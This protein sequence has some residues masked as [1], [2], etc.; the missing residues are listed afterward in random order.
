[1]VKIT[2]DGHQ[3]SSKREALLEMQR[4]VQTIHRITPNQ[5]LE[6]RDRS[7]FVAL[8]HNRSDKDSYG[9]STT[10]QF[11]VIDHP[12]S[13]GEIETQYRNLPTISEWTPFSVRKCI[14]GKSG[15]TRAHIIHAMRLLID[16]QCKAWR[17][18]FREDTQAEEKESLFDLVAFGGSP[19]YACA[20]CASTHDLQVDH[21]PVLFS[22]LAEEFLQ[23]NQNLDFTTE[24]NHNDQGLGVYRCFVSKKTAQQWKAFHL[25]KARFRLLCGTCNRSSYHRT[26]LKKKKTCSSG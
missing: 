13:S 15:S 6:G 21:F 11:R 16:D 4:R 3:F 9:P 12:Y 24:E 26:M 22:E 17:V 10:L 7:L 5:V 18:K 19:A 14:I 2:I 8:I 25:A 20:T 23:S 1:M